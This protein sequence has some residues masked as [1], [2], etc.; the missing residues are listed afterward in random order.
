MAKQVGN[1]R[2]SRKASLG[3]AWR[4]FVDSSDDSLVRYRHDGASLDVNT[5]HHFRTTLR[6][7]RSLMSSFKTALPAAER[8]RLAGRFKTI[9]QRYGGLREWDV[10]R[11][12]LA[13][14]NGFSEAE[15]QRLDAID[16]AA[17]QARE[18]EESKRRR[19][20]VD[21]VA[22][23]H[24][25]SRA[26]WLHKPNQDQAEVWQRKLARVAPEL[27]AKQ[28]RKL[29]QG[30]KSLDINNPA[31]FHKFRI[32]VKKHRYTVEFVSFLYGKK[33]VKD[34]LHRV[35]AMQDLLGEMHDAQIAGQLIE[36]LDLPPSSRQLAA[37]WVAHRAVES[38]KT[39]PSRGKDFRRAEPFWDE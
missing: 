25:I 22:L 14:P 35:V 10:F 21:I 1:G 37:H 4:T 20:K 27:L 7:M 16:R 33:Q 19:L 28:R 38:R 8:K 2:L 30:I 12:A 3:T 15:R 5:I 39:F 9:S 18:A 31:S 34:Y 32:A 36:R 13:Q 26:A 17:A 23:D 24:A 11:E 6:R 29:R